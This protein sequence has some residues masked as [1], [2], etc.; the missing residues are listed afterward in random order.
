MK[1]SA[2]AILLAV[3]GSNASAECRDDRV[4]IDGDFGRVSFTVQVADDVPERAQGLMNVERMDTLAG[5]LFVYDAPQSVA[6]WMENTL[7]P[8]D[9]IFARS[10]GTVLAIHENA[11]PMDRTP[12]PG[13][14]DVQFVLEVN[15]G[16]VD[17]L[18]IEVGDRMQHPSIGVGAAL[19]CP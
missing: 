8:L 6:F 15:G 13:G 5:M 4:T 1:R 18:G 10:D 14:D 11:V 12:I 2:W 17:R 16:L 3:L 19:P 7:I 9:M